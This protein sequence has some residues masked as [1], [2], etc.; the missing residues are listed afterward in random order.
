MRTNPLAAAVV[1]LSVTA[2]TASCLQSPTETNGADDGTPSIETQD[3][4]NP[5]EGAPEVS[6]GVGSEPLPD[7]RARQRCW[8]Y[9]FNRLEWAGW[10]Y[11]E[12]SE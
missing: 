10:C 4:S 12:F 9:R 3:H 8:T 6:G 1:L 2:L 11:F 5:F 7:A